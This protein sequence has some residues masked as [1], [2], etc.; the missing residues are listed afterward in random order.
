MLGEEPR[1]REKEI[2]DLR[3]SILRDR[4]DPAKSRAYASPRLPGIGNKVSVEIS[5]GGLSHKIG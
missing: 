2:C 1:V 4:L 3:A 5:Y